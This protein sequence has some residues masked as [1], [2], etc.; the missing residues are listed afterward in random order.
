MRE[1]R[2]DSVES[3]NGGPSKNRY[4]IYP[5]ATVQRAFRDTFF[6]HRSS[7]VSPAF[8]AFHV[9]RFRVIFFYTVWLVQFN[10]YDTYTFSSSRLNRYGNQWNACGWRHSILF[11]PACVRAHLFRTQ[12]VIHLSFGGVIYHTVQVEHTSQRNEKR[13]RKKSNEKKKETK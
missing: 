4:R 7:S 9:K 11:F 6:I 10:E 13:K 12:N 5:V 3:T 8:N 1:K 2:F